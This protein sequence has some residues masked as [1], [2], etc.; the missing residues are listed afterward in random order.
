M[1]KNTPPVN[2]IIWIM[3]A[4][5]VALVLMRFAAALG[6]T[7]L[8][9]VA[10]GGLGYG[11]Y[12]LVR[13]ILRYLKKRKFARSTEGII[14]GKIDRCHTEIDENREAMQEIRKD[15]QELE[16]KLAHATQASEES[17]SVT[18][19]LIK[20]FQAEL[21][22]REAKINFFETAIKKLRIVLHNYELSQAYAQKKSELKTLR[23]KDFEGI[24][25]L[26]EF[27]SDIEYDRTYLETIDNLSVRMLGSQS[28]ETVAALKLELEEMTRSLDDT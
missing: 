14:R 10:A 23:E 19:K 27:R 24:A 6:R 7:F 2:R 13:Y 11:I 25:D 21:E 4:V 22:L 3:G 28:L 9:L 16:A 12:L 15:I 8:V 20:D 18:R 1:E 17:R 26:E 5:V